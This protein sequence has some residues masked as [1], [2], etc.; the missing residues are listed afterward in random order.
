MYCH[1][2][3]D[4]VTTKEIAKEIALVACFWIHKDV[5]S[6]LWGVSN[7]KESSKGNSISRMFFDIQG[8]YCYT[9]GEQ[10]I[11]KQIAKEKVLVACFW[12]KGLI[13]KPFG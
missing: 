11:T 13:R 6:H 8:M 12:I 1:T 2:N 5:L 4:Q 3:G 10:I 9:N 7:L